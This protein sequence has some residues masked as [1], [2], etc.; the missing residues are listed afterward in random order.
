MSFRKTAASLLIPLIAAAL[1]FQ[2]ALGKGSVVKTEDLHNAMVEA[3]ESREAD[4]ATV[5]EVLQSDLG[6]G[7][8][9]WV[10]ADSAKVEERIVLLSDEELSRLAAQSQKI[11][12]DFAA[13]Q[14]G[15]VIALMAVLFAA[16]AIIIVAR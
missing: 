10:G 14:T 9:A 11:R 7:A 8:L 2:P 5:K 13:G 1:L 15:T 4:L 6:Q 16:L 3:S 12:D